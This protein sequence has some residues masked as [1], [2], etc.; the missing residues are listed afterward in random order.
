MVKADKDFKT[1]FCSIL[2]KMA[3]VI[4]TKEGVDIY[5]IGTFKIMISL[6][7]LAFLGLFL[8]LFG[9]SIILMTILTFGGAIGG[10]FLST[11]LYK[12]KLKY[13]FS[14]KDVSSFIAEKGDFLIAD[15]NEKLFYV[16]ALPEKQEHILKGIELML[17]GDENIL[18]SRHGNVLKIELKEE[19][20]E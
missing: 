8:S 14:Y 2:G 7:G 9:S 16:K 1:D 13:Q 5:V 3:R 11:K 12:G 20:E 10:F 4:V 17:V 15:K 18:A 19:I 6:F